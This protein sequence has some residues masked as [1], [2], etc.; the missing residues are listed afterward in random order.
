VINGAIT[1]EFHQGRIIIFGKA[2]TKS[3]GIDRA[4]QPPYFVLGEIF[5]KTGDRSSNRHS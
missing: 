4:V 2:R 3:K 1:K 5:V